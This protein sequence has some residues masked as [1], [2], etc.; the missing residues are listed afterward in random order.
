MGFLNQDMARLYMGC[1]ILLFKTMGP[2]HTAEVFNANEELQ[3]TKSDC[4]PNRIIYS[5]KTK[6]RVHKAHNLKS[7]LENQILGPKTTVPTHC[8]ILIFI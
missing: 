8:L 1:S 3:D 5:H 6:N 4:L 2:G 7:D